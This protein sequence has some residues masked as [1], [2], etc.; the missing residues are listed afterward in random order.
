MS[1]ILELK[2]AEKTL[3]RKNEKKARQ[4]AEE[5][6]LLQDPQLTTGD[7]LGIAHEEAIGSRLVLIWA[8]LA[9]L[10]M[11]QTCSGFF[12]LPGNK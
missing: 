1:L 7:V 12:Q 8:R 10:F 5:P 2:K 3:S 9:E 11:V 6:H 4:V